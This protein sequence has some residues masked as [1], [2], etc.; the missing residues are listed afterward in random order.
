MGQCE[1]VADGRGQF[2]FPEFQRAEDGILLVLGQ[3]FDTDEV[4]D[5]FQKRIVAVFCL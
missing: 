1:G 5:Y 3:E 2:L 4:V